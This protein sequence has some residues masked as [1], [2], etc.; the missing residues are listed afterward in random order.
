MAFSTIAKIQ[1]YS[2]LFPLMIFGSCK[3]REKVSKVGALTSVQDTAFWQEYHEAYPVSI[4]SAATEVRSIAID[5]QRNAWIATPAGVFTKKTGEKSWLHAILEADQGPSF[6]VVVDNQS[7]VWMST[8][9][10]VYRFKENKLER[11]P[12]AVSPISTL[13][14]ATEGVYALGPNGTWLYSKKGCA[15]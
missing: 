12:G 7:A 10:S 11:M 13:T 2:I 8:W 15:K 6:S 1:V 9:N 3:E 14:V 4:K 5:N